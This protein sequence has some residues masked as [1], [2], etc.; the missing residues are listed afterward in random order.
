[1]YGPNG[2]IMGLRVEHIIKVMIT[3]YNRKLFCTL[4]RVRRMQRSF[5]ILPAT[6]PR[7]HLRL[8]TIELTT[9]FT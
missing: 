5:T 7:E 2:I 8:F 4:M 6:G 3:L 9:S 1:M